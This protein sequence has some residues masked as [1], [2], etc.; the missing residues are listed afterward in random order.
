MCIRDR[1]YTVENA[2]AGTTYD[3]SVPAGAT[4]VAGQGTDS[5]TVNWGDTNTSGT[6]AVAL[7]GN[8][9]T[10]QTIQEEI[11]VAPAAGTEQ[12]LENFDQAATIGFKFATGTFQENVNNTFPNEVNNSNLMGRYRRSFSHQ[13][14]VLIYDI[15][16]PIDAAALVTGNKK[17]YL[18][19]YT[20]APVG[21]PILLQLENDAAA[22][23]TNY[24]TG[25]HSRYQGVTTVR[26][27]WER[28]SFN[29]LD[30]PDGR[31]AHSRVDNIV[32][33]FAP[34][35]FTGSTYHF[36]NFEIDCVNRN[37][38]EAFA[39]SETLNREATAANVGISVL[40]NPTHH[41]VTI[42]LHDFEDGELQV[43]DGT[44]KVVIRKTIATTSQI[45]MSSLPTGIFF[46]QVRSQETGKVFTRK[47]V[48]H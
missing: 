17:F 13:Y 34:N 22:G 29:Y 36:D 10:A 28:V 3:W 14:D 26:N 20:S 40:P 46:L 11:S 45:D 4:I 33:L 38:C 42:Q 5:I 27:A 44:G 32:L 37:I 31:V 24:P 47:V 15:H 6:L 35:S 25:R 23:A 21:T 41:Q 7:G 48:K 19:V 1:V 2:P 43:L 39:V 16:Q 18:D 30:R 8:V 9:C 12:V